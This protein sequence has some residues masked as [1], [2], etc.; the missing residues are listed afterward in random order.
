VA[1]SIEVIENFWAAMGDHPLTTS[2][3]IRGREEYT[4]LC[5]PLRLHGDEVPVTGVGKA[6]QKMYLI[7]SWMLAT[8]ETATFIFSFVQCCS[9]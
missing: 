4:K 9:D 7:L 1:P 8:D 5:V 6:W 3:P 2:T